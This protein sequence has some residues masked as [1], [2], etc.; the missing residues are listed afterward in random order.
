MDFWVAFVKIQQKRSDHE[1]AD[2]EEFFVYPNPLNHGD[3]LMIDF[4][5]ELVNAFILIEVRDVYGKVF[6]SQ[7]YNTLEKHE[8]ILQLDLNKSIASGSYF[9]SILTRQNYFNQ[10]LIIR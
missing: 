4:K 5:S 10:K 1:T 3:N 8:H 6:Y 7:V 9:V 2:I